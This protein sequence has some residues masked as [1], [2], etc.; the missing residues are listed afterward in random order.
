MKR[1]NDTCVP[2]KY[3]SKDTRLSEILKVMPVM[4]ICSPVSLSFN[5]LFRWEFLKCHLNY[6]KNIWIQ[7]SLLTYS[8]IPSVLG[9]CAINSVLLPCYR[10]VAHENMVSSNLM[11]HRHSTHVGSL[12]G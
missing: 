9:S 7:T 5:T 12:P 3:I 2:H 8:S 4:L 6:T 1:L 11:P 10:P